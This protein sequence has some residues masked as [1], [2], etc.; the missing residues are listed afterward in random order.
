MTT[1][2]SD[3][4]HGD[5]ATRRRRTALGWLTALFALVLPLGVLVVFGRQ[6]AR[7]GNV[8]HWPWEEYGVFGWWLVPLSFWVAAA[9]GV[10]RDR[11]GA[12]G[13]TT[14]VLVALAAL[15]SLALLYNPEVAAAGYGQR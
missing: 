8:S 10:L 1:E 9:C 13:R 14:A 3:G 11:P 6:V 12:A 7:T 2:P 15:S 4:A 5:G